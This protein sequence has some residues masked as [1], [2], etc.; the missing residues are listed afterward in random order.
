[1]ENQCITT[2]KN[3]SLSS[4]NVKNTLKHIRFLPETEMKIVELMVY[5]SKL[6]KNGHDLQTWHLW[7]NGSIGYQIRRS[8]ESVRIAKEALQARGIILIDSMKWED[9][10]KEVDGS[11]FRARTPYAQKIEFTKEFIG[12]FKE[13]VAQRKIVSSR[14][15][16]YCDN[17]IIKKESMTVRAR[18]AKMKYNT[19]KLFITVCNSCESVAKELVGG[20][21]HSLGSFGKIQSKLNTKN[22]NRNT[23]GYFSS[24][25]KES[26]KSKFRNPLIA[27]LSSYTEKKVNLWTDATTRICKQ[28]IDSG[29]TKIEVARNMI[30]QNYVNSIQEFETK[31]SQQMNC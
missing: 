15:F 16:G 6:G 22:T 25:E 9:H 19:E 5:E 11:L 13:C 12:W 8:K 21:T 2:Q 28:L 18:L 29:M 1:M 7:A 30:H 27:N 24:Q 23:H 20:V 14:Q 3:I 31:Y 17:Y 26:I 4:I 10:V